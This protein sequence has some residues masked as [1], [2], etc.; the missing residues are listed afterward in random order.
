MIGKESGKTAKR[1]ELKEGERIVGASFKEVKPM[2]RY[3]LQFVI[4]P[5]SCFI[6]PKKVDS[7]DKINIESCFLHGN[8]KQDVIVETM[9]SQEQ[10][11]QLTEEQDINQKL[12]AI[13]RPTQASLNR[14]N[15]VF[16]NDLETGTNLEKDCTRHELKDGITAVSIC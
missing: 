9:P 8:F 12:I 11:D 4:A 2:Y 15:F 16:T 13:I 3:N 1:Y 10:F 14:W 7:T 6:V 5:A